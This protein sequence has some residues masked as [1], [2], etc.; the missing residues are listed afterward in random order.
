MIRPAIWQWQNEEEEDNDQ[1][2]EEEDDY[3]DHNDDDKTKRHTIH[4]NLAGLD[5]NP[6]QTCTYCVL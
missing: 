2:D 6:E 1:D 3:D 4:I 5:S